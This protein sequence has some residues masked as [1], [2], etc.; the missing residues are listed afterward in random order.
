[1]VFA[2]ENVA[3]AMGSVV[4]VAFISKLCNKEFSATQYALLSSLAATART[5]LAANS[6]WIV[7]SSGWAEFFI[8][9]FLSGIPALILIP[10]IA[11]FT[12]T[13]TK[14]IDSAPQNA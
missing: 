6:G 13:G 14:S 5:M 11:K 7:E 1:M 3:S 2:A 8:I 10:F 12:N 9:T 4:L